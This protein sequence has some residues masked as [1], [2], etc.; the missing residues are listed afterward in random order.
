MIGS[1][2]VQGYAVRASGLNRSTITPGT[3]ECLKPLFII[4]EISSDVYMTIA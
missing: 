1:F 3:S 2:S 4:Q